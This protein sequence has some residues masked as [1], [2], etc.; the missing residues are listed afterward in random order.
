VRWEKYLRADGGRWAFR[1]ERLKLPDGRTM[2]QALERDPWQRELWDLADDLR[3]TVAMA[4]GSRGIGKSTFCAGLAVERT[5]VLTDHET[6][7]VAN[8]LDQAR[9]L[10]DEAAGFVR[11]DPMLSSVCTV[12][13]DRIE[14]EH[15]RSRLRVI[16]SDAITAYGLGARRTTFIYDEIWGASRRDLLDALVSAL[17]KVQGSQLFAITNAGLVDTPGWELWQLC[18]NSKTPNLRAWDSR[19]RGVWPSW[20]DPRERERQRQLLPDSV[21]LRL[22]E[23]RWS[24][25]AGD[26]LTEEEVDACVDESLDSSSLNFDDRRRHFGGI[27]LGIRHDRGVVVIGH[28]ER[29]VF[30]VDHIRTWEGSPQNPVSLEDVTAYVQM[31]GRRIRRL[32][33]GY[34]DPWQGLHMLER[35]HKSGLRSIEEYVFS[36]RSVQVL[37]QALWNAFRSRMIRIPPHAQLITELVRARVIERRRHWRVDHEAGQF[38][39]HL[40]AL[41]LAL[42]A[43]IPES[44]DMIVDDRDDEF[45]IAKFQGEITSRDWELFGFGKRCGLRVVNLNPEA[46]RRSPADGIYAAI[47]LLQLLRHTERIS[48][49]EAEGLAVEL[50]ERIW[51]ARTAY[52]DLQCIRDGLEAK[53]GRVHDFYDGGMT[54]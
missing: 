42:V 36:A 27:D 29:E 48:E 18:K 31:L 39:D 11:R 2:G 53:L 50:R 1:A 4:V 7:V 51:K 41:A 26:F 33:R 17:P 16:T 34:L 5:T 3:T 37:S 24:S 46:G 54:Q 14:N 15:S 40:I 35:L 38:S 20:M 49:P 43:A 30:V 52:Q 22:W 9:V 25:G 8:D 23:N 32:R 47:R 6:I 19:D 10:F 45:W 21:Y 13:R 44:G 12:Y 28:K